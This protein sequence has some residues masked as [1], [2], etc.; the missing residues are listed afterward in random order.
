MNDDY[1]SNFMSWSSDHRYHC[2]Y[3]SVLLIIV[4][5]FKYFPMTVMEFPLMVSPV[6]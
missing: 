3:I 4:V 2:L 1:S 6:T 5:G